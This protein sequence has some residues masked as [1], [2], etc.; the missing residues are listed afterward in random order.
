MK[1]KRTFYNIISNLILQIII[2]IYG[3]IVPKIIISNF[4]SSVNGLVSSIT[5][6]LGYIALLESGFGPVVKSILYKPI[7]KKNKQEIINILNATEKFFRV[8]AKVFLVYILLLSVSFTTFINDEY[9]FLYTAS[10]IVIISISSLA[11]YYFGMTYSLFLQAE[12]K[13]YISSVIQCVSYIINIVVVVLLIK[14]NASIHL[15]KAITGIIFI[16]RPLIQNYY[17]KKKYNIDLKQANDDFQI[18]QKWDGLVQH[19]AFVIHSNTDITILTIFTTLKEVSV[20]S[21]YY[22]VVK[23]VRAIIQ[24]FTNGIDALFGNMIA[25]KESLGSK[26]SIY[27]T[28]YLSVVTIF[29]SCTLVLLVSFIE[30]YT[31]GISDTNYIRPL[32]AYLLVI[33]EILYAI[34][35]PY[36][37]IVFAAGHFKETKNGAVLEAVINITISVIFVLK[38]GIIGVIIGTIASMLVR[39]IEFIYHSN[40]YIL[41]RNHLL[42][43]KK[44]LCVFVGVIVLFFLLKDHM[45]MNNISYMSWAANAI[46]VFIV[47]L[48]ITFLINMIFNYNDLKQAYIFM[49]SKIIKRGENNAK[50]D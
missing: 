6:F 49:K 32:F 18:K 37:S 8:I 38:Y 39:T 23:G 14:I 50:S 44:I 42:S 41:K 30:V 10:L 20:Y 9:G 15:I 1:T 29:Y 31:Q 27:E 36:S 16:A 19:I 24:A 46:V 40:K 3:F 5:Q 28:I 12:Q 13:N 33:S 22:M 48:V 2:I 11:E 4:G 17:V 34:R 25:K 43:I 21:V 7:A 35:I 26:F 47:S 45:V